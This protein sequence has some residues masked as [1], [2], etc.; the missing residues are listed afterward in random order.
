MRRGGGEEG[1]RRVL[2]TDLSKGRTVVI[3]ERNM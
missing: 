3:R 1:G 2:H